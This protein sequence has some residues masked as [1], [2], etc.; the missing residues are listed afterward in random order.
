MFYSEPHWINQNTWKTV[1]CC[2]FSGCGINAFRMACSNTSPAAKS[3]ACAYIS[4]LAGIFSW[5]AD[6]SYRRWKKFRTPALESRGEDNTRSTDLTADFVLQ[7]IQCFAEGLAGCILMRGP[8]QP[9]ICPQQLH[10]NVTTAS[11]TFM[12]ALFHDWLLSSNYR[13]LHPLVKQ[14]ESKCVHLLVIEMLRIGGVLPPFLL[15]P[16]LSWNS[17]TLWVA[18]GGIIVIVLAIE[19]RVRGFK[20]GRGRWISEGDKN[21]MHDFLR[22]EEKPSATCKILRYGKDPCSMKISIC[23]V[24]KIQPFFSKFLLLHY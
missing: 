10:A 16:T 1:V 21:S 24:S 2:L 11:H 22:R 20:P 6:C 15:R 7:I 8:D 19:P 3:C 13:H 18:L 9:T 17:A 4:F 5:Y 12:F 14:S 23:L